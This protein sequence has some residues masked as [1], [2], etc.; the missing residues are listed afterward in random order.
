MIAVASAT[1]AFRPRHGT[2]RRRRATFDQLIVVVVRVTVVE[3]GR[4][5]ILDVAGVGLTTGRGRHVVQ[6]KCVIRQSER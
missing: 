1:A 6:K 4:R 2:V 3:G 5:V